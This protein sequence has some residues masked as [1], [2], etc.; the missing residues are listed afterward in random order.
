M[1][2]TLSEML[3]ARET[4]ARRQKALLTKYH[5]PLIS[6][7]MNIAGPVKDSALIR[8]GFGIGLRDLE[9]LLAAER[10]ACL[11]REELTAHTG[12]EAILVADAPAERLKAL[13]TGLE[14][15]SGVGRLFDMDVL[16]PSG[17]KLERAQPRRCLICGGIAQNCARSR[18]HSVM[19]L[20]ERTQA[21]LADA[22][23]AEDC[24]FA[25]QTAQQALL[26]EIGV[27]PKPGLVDRSNNGSHHD[28]DF[29]TFQRSAAAL[30][31]FFEECVQIGRKTR[32]LSA[33]ETLAP[34]RFPGK[35]A[36]G[37]MRAATG[38][39]NTHKGA[40]FS[41]GLLCGA[42]GRLEREAWREPGTVLAVCAE[43]CAELMTDL[44]R[45][46]DTV[47]GVLYREHGI[48]G[49]RGQAA[50][51][52]PAVLRSGL[53]KLEAGLAEGLDVNDAACAALLSLIAETTDTNMI[54]RGGLK[55]Q[56]ETA[57][58]VAALLETA[59]FPDR[60]TLEQLDERFVR[61]N[62]SPGGCADLL[63][64]TL[65]LHFLKEET[66]SISN[67]PVRSGAL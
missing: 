1:E 62:L 63:T 49:A 26:Y 28:M 31:P 52:Y 48:T 61:D 14:E 44:D 20:Q 66:A 55:K 24:R 9:R 29:F 35:L 40:I 13:T 58:A 22:A 17:E 46:E 67:S 19:E 41:L 39:V 8:R 33:P 57:R 42:L 27:T 32:R 59:P 34:P 6:F 25:A 36:E 53:P 30:Y 54:H 60:G 45:P 3:E 64:M 11:H 5:R 47:G 23:D 2:V 4:R 50:A 37:R 65:M 16:T 51:G 10:I 56:R 18:A 12:C 43:M 7:T 38:N 21:I 15:Y